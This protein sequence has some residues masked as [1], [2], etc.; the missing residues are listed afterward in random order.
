M[1]EKNTV[2]KFANSVFMFEIKLKFLMWLTRIWTPYSFCINATPIQGGYEWWGTSHSN[3]FCKR[4]FFLSL[5]RCP[6]SEKVTIIAWLFPFWLLIP[7]K[8]HDYCLIVPFLGAHPLK[9]SQLLG[10]V[11]FLTDH[12]L[13]TSH[14]S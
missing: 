1:N 11:T 2:S 12:L 10:I 6:C 3:T 8:R 14:L 7:W 4:I 5:Y 9:T 13:K